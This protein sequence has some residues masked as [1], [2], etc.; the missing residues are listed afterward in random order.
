[1]TQPPE[2]GTGGEIIR[3][4]EGRMAPNPTMPPPARHT[5]SHG[6]VV[7]LMAVFALI[8][9]GAMFAFATVHWPEDTGRYVMAV[10][11]L[12]VVG[13]IACASI[14]VFTAA[15][16]STTSARPPEEDTSSAAN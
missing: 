16:A 8:G 14:A 6:L 11:V 15:R 5:G 10:F 3:P 12:S 2:P 9:I 4:P 7:T 13:F 1:M